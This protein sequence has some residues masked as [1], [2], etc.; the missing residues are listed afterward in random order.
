MISSLI[1]KAIDHM[2]AAIEPDLS[3]KTK[4][5]EKQFLHISAV[6]RKSTIDYDDASREG[7]TCR[8]KDTRR[9]KARRGDRKIMIEREGR[10]AINLSQR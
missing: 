9:E 6:I 4:V 3:N 5:V 10:Q 8:Q 7:A 1:Q 2:D